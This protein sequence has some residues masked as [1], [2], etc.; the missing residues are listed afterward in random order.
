MVWGCACGLDITVR[1]FFITFS[2]LWTFVYCHF[3]TSMY[4]QSFNIYPGCLVSATPLTVFFRFFW[5]FAD[6]F[7]MV[8]GCACGLDITVRYHFFHFVNLVI[9]WPQ[10]IDSGYLV[11]ATPHTI[12]YQSFWNFAHVFSMVWRCACDLDIILALIFV[13]FSTLRT[14][15]FSDLRLYESLRDSEYLVSATPHTILYRSLWNFAHVFALVWRCACGLDIILELIFITFS[16]LWTLSFSDL[17][18]YE[19]VLQWLP[20]KRNSL[21]NFM[22][23]FMQLCTSFFPW[24]EDVHVVWI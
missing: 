7:F 23:V 14:L 8:W 3:S 6:V 1:L 18:F 19:S 11:S 9:F 2:T 13:T 4:R 17:R 20:C 12:L 5:N 10:F 22:P 21:Y 24:F 15:S 16:T